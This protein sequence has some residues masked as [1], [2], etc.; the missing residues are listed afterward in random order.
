MHL[1]IAL[2]RCAS[3]PPVAGTL[4]LTYQF[5]RSFLL[6][7]TVGAVQPLRGPYGAE[8]APIVRKLAQPDPETARMRGQRYRPVLLSGAHKL[9][10]VHVD[11]AEVDRLRKRL[12][13]AIDQ[14][15]PHVGI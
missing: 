13:D 1:P 15:V 7:R 12:G 14:E 10:P 2:T 8:V 3:L 5:L 4:K 11:V 9:Q 6:A